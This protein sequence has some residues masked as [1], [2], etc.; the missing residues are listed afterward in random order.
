M[1]Y[2]RFEDLPVWQ[3]AAELDERI[4]E[5]L[6][7][8]SFKVSRG[9]RDQLDRAALSVSNN[10]AEG[11]ERGSTN[12]LLAFLYIARGSAGEVRSML[13]LKE[14]RARKAGW[15]ADLDSQI[16]DLKS[17]AESCSRQLR[18]WAD[19][20]QNSD[21]RGQRHLNDK[22]RESAR[23]KNAARSYRLDFLRG[24][25]PGHPLY[26]SAEARAARGEAEGGEI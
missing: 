11:F 22:V 20:L 1:T 16:S 8:E 2:Q 14:R 13:C 10:I 19:S 5:P 9:F 24:L 26:R 12:E 23:L 17:T 7:R 21:I 4:E 6:D 25:K 15:P 18:A 3:K